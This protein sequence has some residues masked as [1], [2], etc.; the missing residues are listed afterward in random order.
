MRLKYFKQILCFCFALVFTGTLSAKVTRTIDRQEIS[1][2]E[3]FVLDIRTDGELDS[4]PDLSQ[5]PGDFTIVS[6]SQYQH[7]QIINGETSGIKG[8][9]IKLKTMKQG[10]ITIPSIDVGSESTQPVKLFIKDASNQVDLDGQAKAIFLETSVDVES[11]YVQQQVIYTIKLYRA[12]NTHYA[13]LTDPVA[14]D[15]VVEKLGEDVQ[16]E[17]DIGGKRYFVYQRKFAIFP[18]K[19]GKIKI[20]PV[21][22]TADVADTRNRRSVFLNSTRPVSITSE[23]IELDV[24]GIPAQASTPW[25]PAQMVSFTQNWTPNTGELKVGEPVTWTLKLTVNGLSESQLPEI[26]LPEMPGIQLYPDTPSKERDTTPE[27][28]VG[29][30]TEKFA[31]IPSVEGEITIPEVTVKWWDINSD[32]EKSTTI[33]ARKFKVLPGA[34][35]NNTLVTTPAKQTSN[36]QNQSLVVSEDLLPWQVAC[37]V[38][39]LAW[40]S[41]LI[42]YL[43]K[44]PNTHS[45]SG[46]NT[47][48][49]S[50]SSK[51][52]IKASKSAASQ[53]DL[54]QLEAALIRLAYS[55]GYTKVKS[56][57]ALMQ[58][59][60]DSS[61]TEKLSKIQSALYSAEQHSPDDCLTNGD[62]DEIFRQVSSKRR[63]KGSSDIP[64]LYPS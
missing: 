49:Y 58:M 45:V 46:H 10:E 44:K 61:L 59:I 20:N 22:F 4:Q 27:G 14:A 40:L 15:T 55:C 3:T 28:I 34:Q 50:E 29:Q 11:P 63:N 51:D 8:W 1:V 60:E 36:E 54:Q 37:G 38:L 12:V 5:I 17:K 2:G 48:E 13:N 25:M 41:T 52:A 7:T 24:K 39:F 19:S 31:V 43:R 47:S 30:R 56:L 16:Y 9:K 23:A 33:P 26:K 64:P 53:K 57:G 35:T 6:T 42:A 62:I 32:S 18:Q 21:N